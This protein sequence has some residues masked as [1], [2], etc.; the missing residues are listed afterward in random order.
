MSLVFQNAM[1]NFIK[2]KSKTNLSERMSAFLE[3]GIEK[4]NVKN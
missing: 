1:E 2:E 3:G 4:E